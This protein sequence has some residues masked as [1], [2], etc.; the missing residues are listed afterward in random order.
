MLVR[1][2]I[3][4]ISDMTAF[5]DTYQNESEHGFIALISILILSVV[6]LSTVLSL[7][8]F[9]IA[10]RYF[11]LDLENKTVSEKLAE[12][13]VHVARISVY[14]DP[15]YTVTSVVMLSIESKMCT[16]VSVERNGDLSTI[17]TRGESGNAITSLLVVVDNTNGDFISW[18]E[19]PT[20]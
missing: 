6:M 10:S 7:A 9:G 8:Q 1:F 3:I 16:I 17:E 11:I 19:I 4:Y 13:C 2:V 12:A 14:N 5:H 18:N 15:T 20:P